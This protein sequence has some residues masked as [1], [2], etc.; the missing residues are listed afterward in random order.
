[1]PNA[2]SRTKVKPFPPLDEVVMEFPPSF[3]LAPD[4]A[5]YI[6]GTTNAV[7]LYHDEFPASRL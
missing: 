6:A 2:V 3:T 5:L 7:T 4:D 1:M